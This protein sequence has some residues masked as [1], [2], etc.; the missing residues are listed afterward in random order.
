MSRAANGRI[1][2]LTETKVSI[3]DVETRVNNM[4]N[5]E[6]KLNEEEQRKKNFL[7]LTRCL[8]WL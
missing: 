4:H 3:G 2:S 8:L 7:K 6:N 5:R 1:L